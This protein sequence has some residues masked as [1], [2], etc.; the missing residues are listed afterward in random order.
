M[1]RTCSTR[2]AFR[3]VNKISVE[4]PKCKNHFADKCVDWRLILKLFSKPTFIYAL[5]AFWS[6]SKLKFFKK[7]KKKN[8]TLLE[9]EMFP[10]YCVCVCVCVFVF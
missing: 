5:L 8:I 9:L 6:S 4:N 7:K 2:R 3:K 10:K 1:S